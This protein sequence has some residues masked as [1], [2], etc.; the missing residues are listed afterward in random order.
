MLNLT[1]LKLEIEIRQNI[2]E[3]ALKDLK[4]IRKRRIKKLPKIPK[5]ESFCRSESRSPDETSQS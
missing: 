2:Y 5:F 3:L 4:V 1:E